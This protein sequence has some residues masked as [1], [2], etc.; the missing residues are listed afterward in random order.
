MNKSL[1]INLLKYNE[2]RI[3]IVSPFIR[4]IRMWKTM[5]CLLFKQQTCYKHRALSFLCCIKP[6][7]ERMR[8][9][10]IMFDSSWIETDVNDISNIFFS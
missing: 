2:T 4:N 8:S 10:S 3:N 1:A 9:H 6:Q 5:L 7:C